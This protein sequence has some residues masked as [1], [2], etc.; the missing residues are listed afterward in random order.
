MKFPKEIAC[1]IS[2]PRKGYIQ[3]GREHA[4][5][6]QKICQNISLFSNLNQ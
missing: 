6:K 1:T 3:K 4:L 2:Q 5:R